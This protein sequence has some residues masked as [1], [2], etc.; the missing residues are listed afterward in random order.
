MANAW[1]VVAT[2]IERRRQRYR[3]LLARESEGEVFVI[4][5]RGEPV[6]MVRWQKRVCTPTWSERGPAEA[7]LSGLRSGFRRPEWRE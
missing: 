2:A 4:R 5:E 7:Y 3:E 1:D 6:W